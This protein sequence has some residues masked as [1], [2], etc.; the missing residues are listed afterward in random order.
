MM[1]KLLLPSLKI[2]CLDNLTECIHAND[3]LAVCRNEMQEL[4][5]QSDKYKSLVEYIKIQ[6]GYI[7][8]YHIFIRC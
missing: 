3:G 4:N 2:V 1:Q 5:T 8:Q 6:P 7:H